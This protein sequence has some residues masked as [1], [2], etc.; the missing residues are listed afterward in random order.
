MEEFCELAEEAR[1]CPQCGKP[2]LEM[3]ATEDSQ[4]LEVE[5]RA[6]RRVIRRKRYRATCDCANRP[7]TVT[8][9]AAPKLIPKG[10]YGISVWVYLLLDKYSSAR[11]T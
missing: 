1:C 4:Q 2:R 10:S 6:Y 11:P 5:V 3:V 7:L 9:A 8:A